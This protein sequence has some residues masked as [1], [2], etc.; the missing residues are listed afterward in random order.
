MAS[1]GFEGMG[2]KEEIIKDTIRDVLRI[3]GKYSSIERLP[4]SV[5][6]SL[7]VSTAEIHTLQAIAESE[8]MRVIDVAACFGISKSAACQMVA[9]LIGKGLLD[10]KRSPYNNKEFQLSLTELGWRAFEAH[11]RLHGKNLTDL[12][13]RLS[14]FSSSQIATISFFLEA[15]GSAMDE[16]LSG[17]GEK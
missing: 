15:I 17:Q 16:R 11:E 10:K 14:A 6:K 3:A 12:V 4:I 13:N 8:R 9:K 5:D 1:V 2:N 7:V